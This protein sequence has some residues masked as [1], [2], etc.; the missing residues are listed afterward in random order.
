MP[1][2]S[3]RW[4]RKI[5]RAG[6]QRVAGLDEV[7]RGAWA[8]P[9][10]AAVVI[11]PLPM[12]NLRSRLSGVRDSKQMTSLQRTQWAEAILGLAEVG[13]GG[14]TAQEVDQLGLIPATRLAMARAL[15]GLASPPDHLLIDHLR[16]P[17]IP[18]PQ[19]PLTFGDQI[20]LSIAAASVVAKVRRDGLMDALDLEHPGFGFAQ[21]KGYGTREHRRALAE[22]GP[23][24][25]HRYSYVPVASR[26]FPGWDGLDSRPQAPPAPGPC[27]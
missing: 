27:P 10:I 4:E 18:L 11:L 12:R 5:L 26:T 3:L 13:V 21:H 23:S 1:S 25:I 9:V 6:A 2:P 19:T 17:D 20:S 24:S 7:G 14:A 8:G 22:R 15:A 16:L